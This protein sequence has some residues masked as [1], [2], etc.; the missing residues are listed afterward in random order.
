ML[1]LKLYYLLFPVFYR[2]WDWLYGCLKKSRITKTQKI[3]F[4]L[5]CTLLSF[6]TGSTACS[7]GGGVGGTDLCIWKTENSNTLIPVILYFKK[8][9]SAVN[10]GGLCHMLKHYLAK[11]H[12]TSKPGENSCG[13]RRLALWK[14]G[15]G[16]VWSA[17]IKSRWFFYHT[18]LIYS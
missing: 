12:S 7:R 10:F 6:F 13:R 1:N 4:N 18:F 9:V 16:L 15:C 17:V 11:N 14:D 5:F 8:K 3:H 2:S